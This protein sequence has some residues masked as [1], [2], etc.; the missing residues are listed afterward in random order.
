MVES[1]NRIAHVMGIQTVAEFV[2][3]QEI[4]NILKTMNVDYVQGNAISLPQL[5]C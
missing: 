5:L 2:E 3:S 4:L 1:F